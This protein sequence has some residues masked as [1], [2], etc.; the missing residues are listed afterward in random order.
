MRIAYYCRCGKKYFDPLKF[1]NCCNYKLHP[2]RIWR[3]GIGRKRFAKMLNEVSGLK[4]NEKT[5]KAWETCRWFPKEDKLQAIYL[6]T[7][8]HAF[9]LYVFYRKANYDKNKF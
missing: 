3:N 8:I 9:D 7:G 6:L 2:L 1:Y 5:I 4:I